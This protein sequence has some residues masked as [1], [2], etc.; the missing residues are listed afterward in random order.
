M[1]FGHHDLTGFSGSAH[2]SNDPLPLAIFE[3]LEYIIHEVTSRLVKTKLTTNETGYDV[4]VMAHYDLLQGV[5]VAQVL[6]RS[7]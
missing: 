6:A 7:I 2:G 4:S 3:L 1:H 5:F